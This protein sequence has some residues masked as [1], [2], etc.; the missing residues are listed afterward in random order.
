MAY[1]GG[2][3]WKLDCQAEIYR[4]HKAFCSPSK[5]PCNFSPSSILD[6]FGLYILILWPILEDASDWNPPKTMR[7]LSALADFLKHADPRRYA[8]SE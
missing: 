1:N 7:L 2:K 8:V 5:L 3:R 4:H 6:F